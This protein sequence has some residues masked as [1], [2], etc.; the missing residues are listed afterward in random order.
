MSTLAKN[1]RLHQ[2]IATIAFSNADRVMISLGRTFFS[3][4]LRIAAPMLSH[5]AN[6]SGYSAGKDDD[7]GRVIPNAS[8][9]LAIVFAV[10]IC[11][12]I[13]S[14]DQVF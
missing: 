1:E 3:K 12:K 7:P 6:F 5:S 13:V 10:Y 2:E 9:A 11:E 14:I 8:A 4:R